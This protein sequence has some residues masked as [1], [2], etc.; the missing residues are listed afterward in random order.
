MKPV[1][2]ACHTNVV[3]TGPLGEKKSDAFVPSVRDGA[4]YGRGASDM[5]SRAP[6]W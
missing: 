6:P 4:L 3:P 2:F 1:C 5:E